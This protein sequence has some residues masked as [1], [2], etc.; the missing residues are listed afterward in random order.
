MLTKKEIRALFGLLHEEL[1]RRGVKAELY[2]V[3]GAVMSLVYNA[4]AS[5]KDVDGLFVPAQ[6][7]RRAAQRVAQ[8]KGL[9]PQWLNDGVKEFLSP[10]GEY[11][12]YLQ[13]SHLT[14]LTAHPKYLLAMKCLA[15]RIGEEFH[16]VDDIRFLLRW[17][18]IEDIKTA[19]GILQEYYPLQ[20]F[21]QKTL[22]LLEELL[23]GKSKPG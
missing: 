14:I 10:A 17:L 13:L 20:R 23:E 6:E 11:E 21:P 2:L 4:R 5:T 19:S 16:D 9:D 1:Q 18:N 8:D 22:Y 3:G 15:A 7:V 12:E